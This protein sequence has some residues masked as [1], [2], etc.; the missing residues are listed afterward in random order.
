MKIYVDAD[1]CPVKE[2]IVKN[3]KKLNLEV[4]MV[5][6]F[7]HVYSDGY[8]KVLTVDK[9]IDSADFKIINLIEKNDLC[10]TSDIGLC[11][12]LL[13]RGSLCLTFNG[14]IV[15][16]ENID[17]LLLKRHINKELRKINKKGTK[18]KK[19]T[20][21]NDDFFEKQLLILLGKSNI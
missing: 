4:I 5:M 14:Y 19:R 13:A 1:A 17:E 15:D 6:D 20:S 2:I 16:N 10:I 9:G 3:A 8:S 12:M 11:S 7:C 18:F 21:E